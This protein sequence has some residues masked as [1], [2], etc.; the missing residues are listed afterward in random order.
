M[1]S[2]TFNDLMTKISNVFK[3]DLYILNNKYCI[4]G[5]E[6]EDENITQIVCL[7][8][9]DC[10]DIIKQ[11]FPD[12]DVVYIKDVKKIKDN[13]DEFSSLKIFETEKKDLLKRRD[14]ILD[15]AL[16]VENWCSFDFS[17]EDI[18]NIFNEGMTYE[19]FTN[20]SKIPS[21]TISKSLFPMVKEKVA[22]SL[23]YQIYIPDND[24]DLIH[25]ITSFDTEWFQIYNLIQYIK[26]EN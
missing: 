3:S 11:T 23:Y 10:S 21:V 5:P 8:T 12:S 9:P 6:S 25:L 2:F 22:K 15:L 20:N 24:D 17:D 16:K 4:G 26:T 18:S 14:K 13:F 19:L 1:A 7:L